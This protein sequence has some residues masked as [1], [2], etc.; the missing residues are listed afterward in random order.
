[1]KSK[2]LNVIKPENI[3]AASNKT[4]AKGV[5]GSRSQIQNQVDAA[6]Q[7]SKNI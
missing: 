2:N 5:N 1:M 3:N 7:L 6:V 4:Q